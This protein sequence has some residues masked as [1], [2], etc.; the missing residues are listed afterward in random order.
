MRDIK[1][2]LRIIEVAKTDVTVQTEDIAEYYLNRTIIL[3][4]EIAFLKADND[5]ICTGELPY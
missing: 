3:E 2:D 1:E 4:S 5:H